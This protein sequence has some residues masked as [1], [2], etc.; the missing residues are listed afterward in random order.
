MLR[1]SHWTSGTWRRTFS[2][3]PKAV[4]GGMPGKPGERYNVL[5]RVTS[6]HW[7]MSAPIVVNNRV[8]L[9]CDDGWK[10]DAPLLLCFDAD[11]GRELWQRPV[12]N[13]DA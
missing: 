2:R 9:M 13:L 5:W 11:I 10:D 1:D 3:S 6:P 12:D 8:F 4:F 7:R